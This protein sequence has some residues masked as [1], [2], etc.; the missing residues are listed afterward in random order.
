MSEG[1]RPEGKAAWRDDHLTLLRANPALTHAALAEELNTS[2]YSVRHHLDGL[3][4]AG[5]IRRLGSRKAGVWE[6]M[7]G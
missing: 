2:R 5:R 6:V 1:Q 3:R 4:K 7:D